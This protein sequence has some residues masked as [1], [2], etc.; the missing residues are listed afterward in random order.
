MNELA[1]RDFLVAIIQALLLSLFP[2][3]RQSPK[4]L[5]V[6]KVGAE[7]LVAAGATTRSV[8]KMG[9]FNLSIAVKGYEFAPE[10]MKQIVSTDSW[11]ELMAA[12]D[13]TP[14][15]KVVEIDDSIG[16]TIIPPGTWDLS[17][18]QLVKGVPPQPSRILDLDD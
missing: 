1:R 6:A 8:Y 12:V 16:P 2:W 18:V 11:T 13:A 17:D 14:G 4:G 3:L 7:N 5:E 10:Q 15:A 9:T